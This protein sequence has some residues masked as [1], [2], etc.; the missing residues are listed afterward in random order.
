MIVKF[1]VVYTMDLLMKGVV[2]VYS[3]LLSCL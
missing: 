1:G 2:T 3:H